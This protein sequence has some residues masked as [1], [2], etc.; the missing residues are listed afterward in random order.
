M[1]LGRVLINEWINSHNILVQYEFSSRSLYSD[2][3][4]SI[5]SFSREGVMKLP[6]QMILPYSKRRSMSFNPRNQT[7][8]YTGRKARL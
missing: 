6:L 4:V 3:E 7:S 8:P 2:Q 5:S 1:N